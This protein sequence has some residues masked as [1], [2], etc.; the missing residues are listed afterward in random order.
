VHCSCLQRWIITRPNNDQ[1]NDQQSNDSRFVCEICHTQYRIQVE[2][3]FKF[4]WSRCCSSQ[5]LGH[6]FELVVLFIM[7]VVCLCLW[8]ILMKKRDS[9][10]SWFGSG[11]TDSILIPLVS[12]VMTILTIL[13]VIKV[14]K[15]WI[16]AN[17]ELAVLPASSQASSTS[18]P[19]PVLALVSGNNDNNNDIEDTENNYL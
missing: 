17:S 3:R 8:P 10:D 1:R 13:T 18:I 4:S 16:R 6:T 2:Y 15:R 7:M 9:Q 19:M 12:I 11:S 14:A 5:S